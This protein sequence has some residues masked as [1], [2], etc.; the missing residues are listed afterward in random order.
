MSGSYVKLPEGRSPSDFVVLSPDKKKG[1]RIEQQNLNLTKLI[2]KMTIINDCSSLLS[3]GL[4]YR[5]P[6]AHSSKNS[7]LDSKYMAVKNLQDDAG[8][9]VFSFRNHTVMDVPAWHIR[10]VVPSQ[11]I[12]KLVP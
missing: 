6:G 5:Y 9:L 8:R 11:M 1:E 4:P 7:G 3:G 12:L 2:H 10:C